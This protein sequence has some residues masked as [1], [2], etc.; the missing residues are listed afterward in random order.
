MRSADALYYDQLIGDTAEMRG[1]PLDC[2]HGDDFSIF[3][4]RVSVSLCLS[5]SLML[6]VLASYLVFVITG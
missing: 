2:C 6:F 4:V 5:V 3:G 1:S